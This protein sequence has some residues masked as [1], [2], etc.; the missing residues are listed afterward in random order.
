MGN[1]GIGT[2]RVV[3]VLTAHL[4]DADADSRR[5]AVE[6]MALTG[7]T[8][9]IEPL[10]RTMHDDP[11]AQV[12]ER[13]ACSLASSG[14][15]T[16]EQR[17]SAV[18]MLLSFGDDPSLDPQTHGW[19]FQA[20][21]DGRTDVPPRVAANTDAGFLA[22]M[23]GHGRG[24]GLATKLVS[25]FP[26]NHEF[27]LPSHQALI[28]VFDPDTGSPL[29]VLD[30]NYVTAIRTAGCAAV[31]TRLLARAAKRGVRVIAETHS[32]LLLLGVQSL[33]A[34][35][36]LDPG[37][38]KL[39]WFQRDSESGTTQITSRDVDGAGRFPDW[40]VDFDDVSLE[41]HDFGDMSDPA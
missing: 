19:A 39:H 34:Q 17:M 25:V 14:M 30:G 24:M 3:Q 29:A 28:C 41:A 22:A 8:Q 5:W 40:P 38:V 20:L 2:D 6:G 10:L 11:S 36:E 9:T 1:R 4:K 32:S 23:P 21:S 12:R 15:F 18:P 27:G 31:S 33:I 16:H 26:G 37:L 35:G 13:A 7:S